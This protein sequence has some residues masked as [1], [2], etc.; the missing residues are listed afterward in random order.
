[1]S[2][3]KIEKSGDKMLT[4]DI[5]SQGRW[6]AGALTPDLSKGGQRGEIAFFITV[7]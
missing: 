3:E 1:V 4:F 7:S 5:S 2:S 6:R